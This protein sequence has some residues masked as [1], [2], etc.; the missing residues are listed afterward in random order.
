VVRDLSRLDRSVARR[1]VAKLE[2][3]SSNPQRF[4]IPLRGSDDHKLRVGDWRVIAILAHA[5]RM[6]LVQHVDHRSRIY[7][8]G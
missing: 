4:F 8:R 5:T 1:I 3:A 2:Q 6:I 7:E